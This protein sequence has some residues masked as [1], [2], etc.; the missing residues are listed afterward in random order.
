MPVRSAESWFNQLGPITKYSMILSVGMTVCVHMNWLADMYYVLNWDK[1]SQSFEL[2]RL[3]TNLVYFGRFDLGFIC[4]LAFYVI[5][6]SKLEDQFVGRIADYVMMLLFTCTIMTAVA[7]FLQI[8]LLS[9]AV[10][11]MLLWVWCRT[12]E[13][14]H[15]IFLGMQMPPPYIPWVLFAIHV[16][17]GGNFVH[18]LVG[19]FAGHLYVN[20]AVI[21]PV[22]R[23]IR[24]LETPAFMYKLFPPSTYSYRRSAG[25]GRNLDD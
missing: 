18:D 15:T 16:L 22:T 2:W 20:L 24:L 14:L 23:S 3:M 8:P 7:Y 13:D 17:M 4:N 19:I 12:N 21:L 11:I 1:I 5:Y 10:L 25:Q 6:Q 9:N